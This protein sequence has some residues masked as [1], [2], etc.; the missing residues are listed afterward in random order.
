MLRRGG[1]RKLRRERRGWLLGFRVEIGA[2]GEASPL[3]R[4]TGLGFGERQTIPGIVVLAV[5][6]ELSPETPAMAS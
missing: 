1:R 4:R 3:A 2:E 5:V 6:G